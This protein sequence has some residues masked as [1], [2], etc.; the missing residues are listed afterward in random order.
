MELL[1]STFIQ[2]L[3]VS[4]APCHSYAFA[5]SVQ[6]LILARALRLE[7]KPAVPNCGKRTIQTEKRI[8]ASEQEL[9]R[10]RV[11]E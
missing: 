5:P 6:V 10:S 9:R 4:R 2:F 7:L 8:S 11:E 1:L 3:R